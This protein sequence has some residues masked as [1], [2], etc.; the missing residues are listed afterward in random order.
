[1]RARAFKPLGVGSLIAFGAY[2]VFGGIGLVLAL[3]Y[4]F[5]SLPPAL[6][7]A[8]WQRAAATV[9]ASVGVLFLVCTTAMLVRQVY[10]LGKEVERLK[11]QQ[12][13]S[14]NNVGVAVTSHLA[15]GE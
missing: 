11:G 7:E 4:L 12:S 1:M 5:E 6:P 3:A 2:I 9:G 13:Q 8:R 15:G 14:G 10:E